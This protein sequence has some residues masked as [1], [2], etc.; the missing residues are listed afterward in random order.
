MED[1]H[2]V[3]IKAQKEPMETWHHLPYFLIEDD[4]NEII[5]KMVNQMDEPYNR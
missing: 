5:K 2:K 4:L 1:F 3:Y